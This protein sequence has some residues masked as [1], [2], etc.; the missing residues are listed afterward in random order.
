MGFFSWKT[1]DT[2]KSIPSFYSNRETFPVVMVTKDNQRWIEDSY[3]GYGIFGG[4]DIYEL[5]AELN[6]FSGREKGIE[7]TFKDNPSGDFDKA[8]KKGVIVPTLYENLDKKFDGTYP[9]ACEYQGY[10]YEDEDDNFLV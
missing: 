9:K 10:I 2:K 3:E 4:K 7:L 5:V 6:G 1:A 8:H